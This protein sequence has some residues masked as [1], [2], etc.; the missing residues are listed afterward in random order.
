MRIPRLRGLADRARFQVRIWQAL[1]AGPPFRSALD[2]IIIDLTH[3]CDLACRNCNRSCGSGQAPAAERFHPGQARRFIA[4]SVAAGKRWRRIMLEGGE[5]TLHPQLEEILD[6]LLAYRRDHCPECEI[7]LST[8]GHGEMARRLLLRPPRGVRLKNSAKSPQAENGLFP[9]N[10]APADLA[11]FS[12]ADFAEACYVHRIFG[13]G[14]TASGYYPHPICGGIDRVFGFDIGLKSLPAKAEDM[15]GQMRRLCPLCGHFREFRANGRGTSFW[16]R[17]AAAMP[18][19]SMSR[20]WVE[21]Y[22]IFRQE[23]PQL[24]RY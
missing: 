2:R 18:P 3:F 9:F 20:S 6:T 17:E 24:T 10:V 21:A 14:L 1:R 13:L 5:P 11:E 22:R 8:N 4:E 15:A 7:V 16:R 19:G 23:P 12:G